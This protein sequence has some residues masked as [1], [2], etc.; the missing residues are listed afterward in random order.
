MTPEQ[1]VA[2]YA[3]VRLTE[4]ALYASHFN[5][6]CGLAG[7]PQPVEMDRVG[8]TFTFQK[9]VIKTPLSPA[10]GG[11]DAPAGRRPGRAIAS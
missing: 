4:S 11:G 9:G 7:H 2:K 6:L 5:D 10:E 1:F 8:E 3:G